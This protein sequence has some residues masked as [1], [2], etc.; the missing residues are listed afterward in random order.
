MQKSWKKLITE[1]DVSVYDKG[2]LKITLG[3]RNIKLTD[4]KCRDIYTFLTKEM[5]KIPTAVAKWQSTY[6]V[7]NEDLWQDIFTSAFEFCE[8]TLLQTFQ[9]KILNR[10]FPCNYILSKWYKD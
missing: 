8:G 9:Y 6:V 4:L 3:K 5:C 1:N 2:Q 7:D 10:F